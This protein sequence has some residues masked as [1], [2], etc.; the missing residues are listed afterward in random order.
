MDRM[1]VSKVILAL[2]FRNFA[3]FAN[4]TDSACIVK[5]NTLI[6]TVSPLHFFHFLSGSRWSCETN[7]SHWCV[8]RLVAKLMHILVNQNFQFSSVYFHFAVHVFSAVEV[9]IKPL[10]Q[11]P[12]KKN[13]I[14]KMKHNM[15]DSWVCLGIPFT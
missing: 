11:L 13:Y 10:V 7:V 14:C 9:E 6:Y 4:D 1:D 2:V 3:A 8:T 12:A 5:S 15:M